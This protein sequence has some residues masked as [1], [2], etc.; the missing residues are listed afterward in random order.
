MTDRW[1]SAPG[2]HAVQFFENDSFR[3]DSIVRFF[4]AAMSSGEPSMIVVRPQTFEAVTN[5]L[6]AQYGIP[7]TAVTSRLRFVDVEAA[8][9]SVMTGTALDLV[10]LEHGF[11]AWLTDIRRHHGERTVWIYG[12]MVDVLCERG[13]HADALR[14]EEL[15]N[16]RFFGPQVSVLC[17]YATRAFDDDGGAGHLAA[18]CRQHTHV[19]PNGHA[20]HRPQHAVTSTVYL[21]ED[22]ES[23]RRA[24]ERLLRLHDRRVRSFGSAEAFLAEVSPSSRGCVIVDLDLPGM[25]GVGLQQWMAA[26]GWSMPVVAISGSQNR[27]LEIEARRLGALIFLRKPFDPRA[28]VH[29]V[30]D[31]LARRQH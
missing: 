8:L 3:H 11:S 26:A 21:V 25:S 22:D 17:G 16:A 19:I 28:I 23:V 1:E 10:R 18:V 30:S 31:A 15:W 5:R 29:A 27:Q 6:A 7:D 2:I 14:L 9:G 13:N 12:E 4:A 24:L 20:V